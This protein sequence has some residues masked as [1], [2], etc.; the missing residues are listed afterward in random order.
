MHA[1]YPNPDRKKRFF[2]NFMYT[3]SVT[4][5][6]MIVP[7]LIQVWVYQNVAGVSILTW[8]LLG[9][10]SFM[11]FVYGTIHKEKPLALCNFLIFVCDFMVVLGVLL[12]K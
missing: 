8:A 6:L 1:V 9:L 12:A 2:D 7:Q 5:P 11:W 3:A 4:G 10:G